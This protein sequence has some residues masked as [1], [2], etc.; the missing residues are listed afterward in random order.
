MKPL[1]TAR[2]SRK[3]PVTES[4]P[5]VQCAKCPWKKSVDPN[6]IPG[7]YSADKHAA[8]KDTI[9]SPGSAAG[10]FGA[11]KVMACHETPPGEER[12]CVGWLA[13]QLGPGNNIALRLRVT[14]GEIDTNFR[15]V[16]P[17]HERFEDT[18]PRQNWRAR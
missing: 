14:T 16:G 6:D 13:N 10:L 4:K 8:L 15:L 3:S 2:A 7:G 5:R 12:H 18:L 17:Q 1:H 9:A 11:M